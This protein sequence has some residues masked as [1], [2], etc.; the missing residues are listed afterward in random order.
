[1]NK[2]AI[3]V[4]ILIIL[5]II[6]FGLL[7]FLKKSEALKQEL[8]NNNNNSASNSANNSGTFSAK[9]ITKVTDQDIVSFLS[10]NA[11]AK[12]YMQKNKDFK[13]TAKAILTKDDITAGQTAENFKEVYQGLDLEAH[14][15]LK[16]D[17]MN[18]TGDK[19]L[20]AVL[21]FKEGK[22]LK[23]YGLILLKAGIG[24]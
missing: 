16:V 17:L 23:A 14:R 22:V 15:Y 9:D 21:D 4:I 13:I 19:G 5:V 18:A 24:Q 8:P 6:L 2:F 3:I 12:D 7:F 11:D 1:M 20:V 10:A